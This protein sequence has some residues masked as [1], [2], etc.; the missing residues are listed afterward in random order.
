MIWFFN[1]QNS[2]MLPAPR[3]VLG[4]NAKVPKQA[5][6]TTPSPIA[7]GPAMFKNFSDGAQIAVADSPINDLS[8]HIPL[9]VYHKPPTIPAVYQAARISAGPPMKQS[10]ANIVPNTAQCAIHAMCFAIG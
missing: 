7:N 2:F 1:F 5:T 8:F 3:A 6:N 10:G 9:K 4:G